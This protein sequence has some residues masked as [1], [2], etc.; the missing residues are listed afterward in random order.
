MNIAATYLMFMQIS[1]GE[2]VIMTGGEQY[3]LIICVTK[4][5]RTKYVL[6]MYYI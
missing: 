5:Y 1:M 4:S 2:Y 6:Q 3:R